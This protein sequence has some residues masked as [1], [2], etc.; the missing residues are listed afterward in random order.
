[1]AAVATVLAAGCGSGG[2]GE[3]ETAT[4]GGGSGGISGAVT[5][6]DYGGDWQDTVT[7]AW[8]D[9][10][11]EANPKVKIRQVTT[12]DPAKLKA[13]VESGNVSWDVVD[14]AKSDPFD[15]QATL[16]KLDCTIVPCD[17]FVPEAK[18]DGY[19]APF[20]SFA[21]VNAYNTE[22]TGGQTPEG[23]GDFFDTQKFGGKRAIYKYA[24]AGSV[25]SALLADGV[26]PTELYPL[27]LDRAI[28]KFESIR[29][30]IIWYETGAQ[31]ADLVASGEVTMGQCWNGRM[32]APAKEGKPVAIDWNQ[33]IPFFG[34]LGIPKGSKNKDTAMQLIADITSAEKNAEVSRFIPYGPSNA[35]AID[36]VD[37]A[38]KDQT[39]TAHK[40]VCIQSDEGYLGEH[41]SEISAQLQ[42]WMTK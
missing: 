22:K 35:K 33:C 11:A 25:E 9:P 10:F 27:D 18:F 17:E 14:T 13:M 12:Y 38:F 37:P 7:K 23:W 21:T 34:G 5:F 36:K 24:T 8:L 31:C 3:G 2:S 6:V 29:K 32:V 20:Y 42:E 19:R 41:G 30:D 1:V 26:A 16:E 15:A 28:K 39:P 4:A 40:D